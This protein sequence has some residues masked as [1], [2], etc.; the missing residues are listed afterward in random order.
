MNNKTAILCGLCIILMS[1]LSCNNDIRTVKNAPA[2]Y[3]SQGGTNGDLIKQITGIKGEATWKSFQPDGYGSNV[4]C[5]Q[6][7]IDQHINSNKPIIIQYFLNKETG[8]VRQRA[9]K[10]IE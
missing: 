4:R 7:N 2:Q 1:L 5:V 9:I 6:V 10:G 8:L 3:G